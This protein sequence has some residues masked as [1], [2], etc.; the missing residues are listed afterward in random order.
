M[1]EF[2]LAGVAVVS[3]GTGNTE[4]VTAGEALTAGRAAYVSDADNEAYH[5]VSTDSAKDAVRGIIIVGAAEN[6]QALLAKNNVK[7][8]TTS[9]L[10][11]GDPLILDGAT[12]PGTLEHISLAASTQYVTTLGVP[13]TANTFVVNI[14][15]SGVAKP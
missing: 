6:E 14:D 10:T 4:W 1:A 11:V 15:I 12:T 9:T 8:R 5:G 2:T 13:D 3:G 7:V